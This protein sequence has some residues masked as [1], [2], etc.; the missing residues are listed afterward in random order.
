M[1]DIGGRWPYEDD[2]LEMFHAFAPGTRVEELE[3]EHFLL[4]H[5]RLAERHRDDAGLFGGGQRE[6]YGVNTDLLQASK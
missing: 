5:V 3:E 2:A 1:T 4:Q 6:P